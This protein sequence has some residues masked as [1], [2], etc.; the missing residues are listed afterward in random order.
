[1]LI[2]AGP[3]SPNSCT[4]RAL[5]VSRIS[6]TILRARLLTYDLDRLVALPRSR[7]CVSSKVPG[8]SG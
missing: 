3:G 8:L 5:G 7:T 4:A 6:V 1:M 2:Y